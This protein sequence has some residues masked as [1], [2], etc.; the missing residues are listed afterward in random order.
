MLQLSGTFDKRPVMS[1]RTGAQVATLGRA[2]VN[3]NNLKIEGFYCE[4]GLKRQNLILLSQDIRDIIKQ[5]VVINDEDVLSEPDDLIRLQEVL[6]IDLQL[7]N[8]PVYTTDKQKVG[9]INDYAVE[10]KTMYIQKLYV[11]RPLIK[12]FGTGQL[13]VDRNQIIEITDRKVII[14]DPLQFS[15]SKAPVTSPATS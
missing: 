3:P 13:S 6:D 5:G 14:Q 15:K 9:K 2:I 1:L 10:A 8:M 12:S 11:G 7:M 4:A